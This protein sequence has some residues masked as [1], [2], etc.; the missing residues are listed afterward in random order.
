MGSVVRPKK[1]MVGLVIAVMLLLGVGTLT[2]PYLEH[3]DAAQY[4]APGVLIDV[5]GTRLHL[6]CVGEGSPTVVMIAGAGAPSVV[7]YEL[8]DRIAPQT[9]VCSYDRAG[10]GWSEPANREQGVVEATRDLQDLLAQ[11]GENGPFVVVPESYGGMV[12]LLAALDWQD[13]VAGLVLID[14][15]EPDLWFEKTAET[16]G[17]LGRHTALMKFGWRTGIIRA[18]LEY[19]QPDWIDEMSVQNREWF[20][21]I[22]SRDMPGYR[23]YTSAIRLTDPTI[24]DRL[25]SEGLGN[26]PITVLAHGKV[27]SGLPPEFEDGWMAAQ[28]KLAAYSN[29]SEL[30]IAKNAGHAIAGEDPDLVAAQVLLMIEHLRDQDPTGFIKQ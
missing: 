15:S 19:G 29:A 22:Y 1:V 7:S 5:N 12:A 23:E 28:E 9:R 25:E 20:Q 13:N 27:P 26:L 3:K 21:A 6:R 4:P 30:I 10:L 8:Q 16:M 11:A 2:Q 18:G 17:A 24:Y 14:A